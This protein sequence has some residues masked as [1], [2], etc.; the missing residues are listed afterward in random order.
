MESTLNIVPKFQNLPKTLGLKG[1][2]RDWLTWFSDFITKSLIRNWR[3]SLPHSNAFVTLQK[4]IT[5]PVK[6][7][8]YANQ[9]QWHIDDQK[10]GKHWDDGSQLDSWKL[11]L[12]LLVSEPLRYT[13]IPE[14]NASQAS[15]LETSEKCVTDSNASRWILFIGLG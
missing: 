8:Y 13:S 6:D 14:S 4:T 11:V 12:E 7:E 5:G 15:N 2:V 9:K 3:K 1:Y 10:I